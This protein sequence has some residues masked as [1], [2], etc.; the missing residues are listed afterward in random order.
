MR[1]RP[2]KVQVMYS[3]SST[4]TQ[5]RSRKPAF[6]YRTLLN[7]GEVSISAVFECSGCILLNLWFS[8]RVCT[9]KRHFRMRYFQFSLL[10]LI[11]LTKKTSALSKPVKNDIKWEVQ[12]VGWFNSRT[13]CK[14]YIHTHMCLETRELGNSLFCVAVV[15]LFVE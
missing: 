6:V 14:L 11:F 4:S 10:Y 5:I 7:H 15:I 2:L 8:V 13:I 9:H 1:P 12:I 3:F